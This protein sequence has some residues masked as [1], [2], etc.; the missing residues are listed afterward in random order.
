M[1]MSHDV[2]DP[3]PPPVQWETPAPEPI[4]WTRADILWLV[5]LCVILL[6]G[7]AWAWAIEP[8]LGIGITIAGLFV[9]LE[10]WF[11]ALTFLHRHPHN[12]PL[13]RGV[14]FLVAL[15]P[16]VIGIGA[17]AALL[18]ALFWYSDRSG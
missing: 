2:Y 12:R 10:S 13:G 17:A 1:T 4:P 14:I 7:A 11:S 6:I 9:I 16:W 3:P 5:L 15:L 8:A 18:L